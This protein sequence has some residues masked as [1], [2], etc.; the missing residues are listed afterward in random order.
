M[1]FE[2]EADYKKRKL[3][4][5]RVDGWISTCS[6][7][8]GSSFQVESIEVR[9]LLVVGLCVVIIIIEEL[10]YDVIQPS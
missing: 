9:V 6:Q 2:A 8:S 7:F 3:F 4:D 1:T 5:Q 10:K